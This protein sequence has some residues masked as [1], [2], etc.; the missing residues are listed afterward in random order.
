MD[1]L[2]V[3]CE[4]EDERVRL[5]ATEAVGRIEADAEDVVPALVARLDED[6]ARLRV[7]ALESLRAY[8]DAWE[9]VAAEFAGEMAKLLD[10][11]SDRVRAAAERTW[12]AME[13]TSEALSRRNSHKPGS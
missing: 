4:D 12:A 3:A 8:R 10:D 7:A 9:F 2:L 1:E 11:H 13:S 5:A 6:D